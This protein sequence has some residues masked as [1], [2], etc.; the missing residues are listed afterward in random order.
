MLNS[1]SEDKQLASLQSLA[2]GGVFLEIG[3]YDLLQNNTLHLELMKKNAVFHGVCLD[4]FFKAGPHKKD[5]LV[6]LVVDGISNG[7]VKPL[8]QTCFDE[9]DVE[10]AYRYMAAGKHIGKVLVKIRE[11]DDVLQ[12]NLPSE[13]LVKSL[14]R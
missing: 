11:E 12:N 8:R 1:L 2:Y 6:K 7:F 9:C 10:E 5:Q 14:P 13:K 3:K 4:K